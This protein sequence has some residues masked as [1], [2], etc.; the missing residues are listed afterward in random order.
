MEK[1]SKRSGWLRRLIRP[2]RSSHALNTTSPTSLPRPPQKVSDWGYHA[3]FYEAP[4]DTLT[5]DAP[6]A[7]TEG[8]FE[9]EAY[10]KGLFELD[11]SQTSSPEKEESSLDIEEFPAIHLVTETFNPD[12]FVVPF[13]LFSHGPNIYPTGLNTPP[14]ETWD[15]QI[16]PDTLTPR[17]CEI[18]QLVNTR[19]DKLDIEY[20]DLEG[21]KI[22]IAE[23]CRLCRFIF[24]HALRHNHVSTV[25]QWY[26][27][28]LPTLAIRTERSSLIFR[29]RPYLSVG[30]ELCRSAGR[31]VRG[32]GFRTLPLTI[33]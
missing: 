32:N 20:H 2:N 9:L 11:V 23:G 28:Q 17:L 14:L 4:N 31:R 33:N 26:S 3:P 21:L 29:L 22:A 12:P 13:S 25:K 16:P 1:G 7:N 6:P 18:C 27:N 5:V 30:F 24:E 15:V 19:E 10:P 8:L